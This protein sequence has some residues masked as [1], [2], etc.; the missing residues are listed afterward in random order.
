M[1][2]FF[3]LFLVCFPCL[4]WC[5]RFFEGRTSRTSC[6]CS[7]ATCGK[8]FCK[9]DEDERA[10]QGRITD[11]S[12]FLFVL[13]PLPVSGLSLLSYIVA[14]PLMCPSLKKT[15]KNKHWGL[16]HIFFHCLVSRWL[17]TKKSKR[18]LFFNEHP[19][20]S[21]LMTLFIR[22]QWHFLMSVFPLQSVWR[23][24][25]YAVCVY[26]K[27]ITCDN[28]NDKLSIQQI[29]YSL[30]WYQELPPSFVLRKTSSCSRWGNL[31]QGMNQPLN[32]GHHHVEF[33]HHLHNR[34][35][36]HFCG[37]SLPPNSF[38][39]CITRRLFLFLRVQKRLCS[40]NGVSVNTLRVDIWRCSICFNMPVSFI[41]ST[42][43]E[44]SDKCSAV[45]TVLHI[46]S[47]VFQ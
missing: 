30:F 12:F 26:M 22:R 41:L 14:H 44:C 46:E 4:M 42:N 38:T 6:S 40:L 28:K 1:H 35:K 16:L 39:N 15:T 5:W 47:K 34:K 32:S 13:L 31:L 9:G 10:A 2:V 23:L 24:C 21:F 18:K 25:I 37:P 3:H 27:C 33:P 36:E 19:C 45:W 43:D 11:S 17:H 8:T 29:L 7:C 20:N